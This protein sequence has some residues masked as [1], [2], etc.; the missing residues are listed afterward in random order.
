MVKN[1]EEHTKNVCDQDYN[2]LIN[3]NIKIFETFHMLN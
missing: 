3:E 2:N 1:V